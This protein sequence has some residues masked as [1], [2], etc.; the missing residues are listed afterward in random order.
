MSFVGVW[1]IGPLF[2]VENAMQVASGVFTSRADINAFLFIQALSSI[3]GFILTPMMFSVLETGEFKRHL[4]LNIPVSLRMIFL[5]IAAILLVQFFIEMLVKLNGMIPLPQSLAF[6]KEQEEK[7]SS[8]IKALLDFKSI[9]EFIAVSFVVA[10]I[11]AVGEE[12]FFRGLILGNLL[13]NRVNVVVSILISALLFA[14]VHMEYE[15]TLAIWAL[16]GLLGYLYYV[17][18]SLWLPIVVHFV[19]N[20]L[21]VLLKYLHNI[22]AVSTDLTETSAPLYVTLIT[23][24]L[25]V[26]CLYIFHQWRNTPDF[27]LEESELDDSDEMESSDEEEQS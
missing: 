22:G 3:G 10:V 2:G 7:M 6:L 5:G 14:V 9:G 15:N 27:A 23:S 8:V 18:G 20:F 11:P 1:C 19:N 24:L 13:K 12:M 17:S 26:G 4:R 25:F 21:Q 16:G